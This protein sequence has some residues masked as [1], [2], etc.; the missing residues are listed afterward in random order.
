MFVHMYEL[1][2]NS[3]LT[4]Y[5]I[6]CASYDTLL[7]VYNTLFYNNIYLK[8]LYQLQCVTRVSYIL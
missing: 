2:R 7:N 1:K 8:D 5:I 3:L 4:L 6:Y